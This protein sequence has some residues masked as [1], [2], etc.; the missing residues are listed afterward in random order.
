MRRFAA[1][2][3]PF[4][5]L[6]RREPGLFETI[7]GLGALLWGLLALQSFPASDEPASLGVYATYHIQK[8][9]GLLLIILGIGQIR[10]FDLIDCHWQEHWVR[11]W[12]SWLL[13]T[14]W[15][16]LTGSVVFM[17]GLPIAPGTGLIAAVGVG[18]CV[19][20]IR[21]IG[22]HALPGMGRERR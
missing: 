6:S 8:P 13:L 12:G 1:I 14:H 9:V 21:I 17:G 5:W 3:R 22:Q 2:L 16:I 18:C 19:L 15:L 11:W 4:T 10:V 20:C 7:S